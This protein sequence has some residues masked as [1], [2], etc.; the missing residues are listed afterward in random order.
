MIEICM[1][2]S[3]SSGNAVYVATEN[4]R[5]L[6]DAGLSGRRIASALGQIGVDPA[7]L[8]AL[9]ISHDHN[10]HICGAGV[11][12]RR[13][14]LPVLATELT[15]RAAMGKL[16]PL[17]PHSQRTMP[18]QGRFSHN[19]LV[20]D[21]FPL[22]HDA[23]D[24]VGFLFHSGGRTVALVTDLG[25]VTENIL[26]RLSSADCLILEA[27][28]DEDMVI[29]GTYPW[30]LKKRILGN[31]GHLSNNTAA[32]VLAG[33]LGPATRNVV[34]AHLS[35]Q[36]NLP[37]LA[38][39]TVCSQLEYAGRRPGKDVSVHVAERYSPSCHIRLV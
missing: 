17:P 29:N 20:I 32:K 22:P 37:K 15:W 3:G 1:L 39:D 4:T 34:L 19:D 14:G 12:A 28:H 16:G 31:K 5:I 38:F 35:E 8:D 7:S 6:I 18:R 25:C 36:N 10:D 24:P 33:V 9:L 2:A 30:P 11:M 13:Y 26:Q 23:A 21:T 27:N